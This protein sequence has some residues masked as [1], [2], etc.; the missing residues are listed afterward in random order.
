MA[1]SKCDPYAENLHQTAVNPAVQQ[2]KA[3]GMSDEAIREMGEFH[4]ARMFFMYWL[5]PY[6]FLKEANEM[7]RSCPGLIRYFS[8]RDKFPG[9]GFY[10][11]VEGA[12]LAHTLYFVHVPVPDPERK[13]VYEAQWAAMQQALADAMKPMAEAA[14]A[15]Q[16]QQQQPPQQ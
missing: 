9:L 6:Q 14:A 2:L 4:M 16:Q 5:Q 13:R 11:G 1:N 15:A 12:G 10:R 3:A 7:L 8:Q